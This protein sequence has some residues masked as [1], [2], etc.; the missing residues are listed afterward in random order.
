M[1]F[2]LRLVSDSFYFY[3]IIQLGREE[4]VELLLKYVCANRP[5]NII[6]ILNLIL[7]FTRNGV[8]VNGKNKNSSTALDIAVEKGFGKIVEILMANGA[9]PKIENKNGKTAIDVA[10]EKGKNRWDHFIANSPLS[11]CINCDFKHFTSISSG[12]VTII[13]ALTQN[14]LNWWNNYQL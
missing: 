13:K 7:N 2:L 5:T 9:N 6:L 1:N 4:I 12:I 14:L 11:Y 10:N 8:D 3:K